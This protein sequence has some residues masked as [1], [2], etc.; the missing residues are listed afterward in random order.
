ML[1]KILTLK[2]YIIKPEEFC[3]VSFYLLFYI[4]ILKLF[5]FLFFLGQMEIAKMAVEDAG[6]E[7]DGEES[8]PA[9]YPQVILRHDEIC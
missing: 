7:D 6:I 4:R 2:R 1:I 9:F 3:F 5:I 8:N